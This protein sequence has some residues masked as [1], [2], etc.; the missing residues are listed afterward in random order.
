MIKPIILLF[1]LF[2]TVNGYSQIDFSKAEGNE[3]GAVLEYSPDGN[4]LLS[5]GNNTLGRWVSSTN[6]LAKSNIVRGVHEIN[7]LAFLNNDTVYISSGDDDIHMYGLIEQ[8]L[9]A[10]L[11]G[12][13][14]K[15]TSITINHDTRR[16]FSGSMDKTT[17][18]WDLDSNK[19]IRQFKDHKGFVLG[20][21]VDTKNGRFASCGSDGMVNVY[22]S[23]GKL[24]FTNKIT[25]KW[26]WSIAFSFD[27][28]NIVAGG[29][30][31]F[32]I[33]KDFDKPKADI[34][35]V[36]EINGNAIKIKFSPDGKYI[37]VGTSDQIVYLFETATQKLLLKKNPHQGVV[38][39]LEFDPSGKSMVTSHSFNTN[40][41]RWDLRGLNILPSKYLKDKSDKSPPQIYVANP[42]R[43]TDDRVIVY[44][45]Q[46]N[47]QGTVI[48]ESGI[49]KL[50]VGGMTSH[51]SDNGSFTVGLRLSIGE[52][53]VVIEAEDIN[54]NVTIRK[55]NIIRKDANG[56]EYDPLLAKNHLLVIG[57]NQYQHFTPLQNAI[58]DANAISGTL[59][60]L[61]N[62]DFSDVTMLLDSQATRTNIYN[63]LRSYA[64]KVG[65]KDNFMVYFSGHGFFDDVL[66]EGYWIPVDADKTVGDYLSNS[67]LLKII[68]NINSQHTLIVSDAC[69]AGSL[70][71]ETSRGFK[72][73]KSEEDA[74]RKFIDNIEKFRSR[75]GLASG[76]LEEVSDGSAGKNSPFAQNLLTFLR[77]A[78]FD[79]IAISEIVQYVKTK[80]PAG[81]Q[82][83]PIGNPLKN[84]GDE[85][86]EFIFYK[87]K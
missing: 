44:T 70:F 30:D 68:K 82:Q 52:N 51:I 48:D 34:Q 66:N 61:Y 26:L 83:T 16:L 72:I 24:L 22:D 4:L 81:S 84:A 67:E 46:L 5:G 15:I 54:N 38:T 55:L 11:K 47:L 56:S 45:D 64:E 33:I 57:I 10:K 3:K 17:I 60:G 41:L 7:D 42:P 27:G 87:R 37:G 71:N 75:W 1:V 59:T 78:T 23:D 39:D 29:Q 73:T 50:K 63:K 14:K 31:D 49:F 2:I 36:N 43:I 6:L 9:G 25:E 69:F 53:P 12:H 40:L 76:R 35:R 65:P 79:K 86:G 58:N 19:M 21:T 28:K 8:K 32:Y 74:D 62:F 18:L 77:T 85:G 13:S 20:T 80:V